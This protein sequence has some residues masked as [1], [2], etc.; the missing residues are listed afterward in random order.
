MINL[1]AILVIASVVGAAARYVYK[2]KKRG[3]RCVGCPH[4]C[5]CSGNCGSSMDCRH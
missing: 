3:V 2:Q 5:S 4:G 1:I